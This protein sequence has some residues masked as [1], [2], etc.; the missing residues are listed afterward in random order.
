MLMNAAS[1]AT[2]QVS[3]IVALLSVAFACVHRITRSAKGSP[4]ATP[5]ANFGA[6]PALELLL[7]QPANETVTAAAAVAVVLIMNLR[8]LLSQ[9]V[10]IGLLQKALITNSGYDSFAISSP[11][12][13]RRTKHFL[14]RGSVSNS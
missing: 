9:G 7:E 2:C 10:V 8:R 14:C 5:N 1:V 6:G 11:T 4:L 3:G 12:N 13:L